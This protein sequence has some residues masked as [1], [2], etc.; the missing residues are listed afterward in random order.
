MKEEI[1]NEIKKSELSKAMNMMVDFS[2]TAS[3]GNITYDIFLLQ[4]RYSRNEIEFTKSIITKEVFDNNLNR[5]TA[6][7]LELAD[8]MFISS[9]EFIPEER[10]L[11]YTLFYSTNRKEVSTFQVIFDIES[12]KVVINETR[13]GSEYKGRYYLYSNHTCLTVENNTEYF[14]NLI[15]YSG[16]FFPNDNHEICLGIVN[17]I[18]LD[19]V[20]CSSSAVL[21][22]GKNQENLEKGNELIEHFIIHRP[23]LGIHNSIKGVF[24]E[25]ELRK[26]IDSENVIASFAG[27]YIAV[28]VSNRRK[29]LVP[30][31]IEVKRTGALVSYREPKE[32][33]NLEGIVHVIDK[34]VITINV[35]LNHKDEKNYAE[36]RVYVDVSK[37]SYR[38][39]KF[40]RGTYSSVSFRGREPRA[41]RCL[42]IKTNKLLDEISTV[43]IKIKSDRFKEMCSK[44]PKMIEYLSGN[45]DDFVEDF[46]RIY[47]EES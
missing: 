27:I 46:E 32:L 18:G 14:I 44:C 47:K 12:R 2:T 10:A 35:Y 38:N 4:S 1:I 42:M 36:F 24:Y 17:L 28:I 3:F 16:T 22:K 39:Y 23:V 34:N 19:G 6:S 40:Y 13:S 9:D 26:R 33:S 8:R 45:H 11:Y 20:A 15:L 7:L 43:P 37:E 5:I 30:F 29:S 31:A 41:G 21:L 25:K